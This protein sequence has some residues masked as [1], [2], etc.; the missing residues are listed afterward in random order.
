MA[1]L[2]RTL[3]AGL[4]AATGCY[5]PQL[6]D[7]SVSCTSAA[8]CA[9]T[10]TCGSD[11]KCAAPEHAGNCGALEVIDAGTTDGSSDGR[12]IDGPNVPVDAATMQVVLQIEIKDQGAVNVQGIGTC[13]YTAPMHI[14]QFGVPQGAPRLLTASPATDFRFEKW[15]DPTCLGQDETC[16]F[17]PTALFTEVKAKF[18]RL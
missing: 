1:V 2:S 14:C 16:T 11:G 15:E 18:K 13:A 4:L 3:A 9:P 8:D 17:I 12:V 7:C 5:D 10:Q 6:R